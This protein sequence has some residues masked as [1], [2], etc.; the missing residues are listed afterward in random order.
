[1]TL[2]CLLTLFANGLF[3]LRAVV[4]FEISKNR[5]HKK[6][7]DKRFRNTRRGSFFGDQ[8]S[9]SGNSCRRRSADLFFERLNFQSPYSCQNVFNNRFHTSKN[10]RTGLCELTDCHHWLR[11]TGTLGRFLIAGTV[12]LA[13]FSQ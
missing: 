6:K 10:L 3:W 7:V 5:Y 4:A 8:I 2:V 13:L 9:T 11:L 12:H 1:M